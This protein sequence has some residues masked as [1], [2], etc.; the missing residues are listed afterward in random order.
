MCRLLCNCWN[1]SKGKL[2]IAAIPRY[3]QPKEQQIE[4]SVKK[5]TNNVGVQ[6]AKLISVG[7]FALYVGAAWSQA[8][9]YFPPLPRAAQVYSV[10]SLPN[11]E[12]YLAANLGRVR[13]ASDL[14]VRAIDKGFYDLAYK[15]LAY[16]DGRVEIARPSVFLGFSGIGSNSGFDANSERNCSVRRYDKDESVIWY[17]WVKGVSCEDVSIAD[18]GE[19]WLNSSIDVLTLRSDGT[20]KR[21]L[22][23]AGPVQTQISGVTPARG[24]NS[25]GAFIRHEALASSQSGVV[26]YLDAT[27]VERWRFQSDVTAPGV[28]ALS[29]GG[30]EVSGSI[31]RVLNAS[32]V[33]TSQRPNATIAGVFVSDATNA[34]TGERWVLTKGSECALT[35][36]S[37]TG[38]GEWRTILP[39]AVTM[40]RIRDPYSSDRGLPLVLNSQAS[41]A[42]VGKNVVALLSQNGA[43]IATQT[44]GDNGVSSAALNP[45]GTQL[46]YVAN[47]TNANVGDDQTLRHISVATQLDRALN[48]PNQQTGYSPLRA[49]ETAPDGTTF[50]VTYHSEDSRETLTAIAENGV[51]RWQKEL[52]YDGFYETLIGASNRMVCL[53]SSIRSSESAL[54]CW[55]S[56]TGQPLFELKKPYGYF[57]SDLL[58]GD[59][60][61]APSMRVYGDRVLIARDRLNPSDPFLDGLNVTNYEAISQTGVQLFA[62]N[63]PGGMTE[64]AWGTF[65]LIAINGP[66]PNY[67]LQTA[68]NYL[69]THGSYAGFN[70]AD[71]V[72][73]TWDTLGRAIGSRTYPY[74]NSELRGISV[75]SNGLIVG[76]REGTRVASSDPRQPLAALVPGTLFYEFL[77][78]AG[79][80][81][82]RQPATAFDTGF[83]EPGL[84]QDIYPTVLTTDRI[85]LKQDFRATPAALY[86]LRSF[87]AGDFAT[88]Q[89]R[90]VLQKI[91]L[92]T[93]ALI[94]RKTV[95][96]D[97]EVSIRRGPMQA[98]ELPTQMVDGK[99]QVLVYGRS[100]S[101][102]RFIESVDA[103]SGVSLDIQ[104]LAEVFP[105]AAAVTVGKM[106]FILRQP[107]PI[108]RGV[109]ALGAPS[110]LG[111]W[112]NPATPGQGFFIER[113][114]NTQFMAWFHNDW[115]SPDP[116]VSNFLS[117]ARQRWLSLQGELA[118][119]ATQ[120]ELKIY[121]TSGGSFARDSAG[122]PDEIGRATLRFSSCDSATLTYELRAQRCDSATCVAQ[123]QQV[124]ML[125]GVIPLRALVPASGCATPLS[126]PAP[127]SAKTGLF[128][129]P[130]VSGQG[131]I[132]VA[133]AGTL[134]AGWF[135]RDPLGAADDPQ[136]QA[137][138][139]LQANLGVSSSEPITAK[140]YRTLGGRRDS[141]LSVS[142][143]EVG[144]ATLVFA[145]CD[146][147][148][149]RYQFGASDAVKP[150][151]NLAGQLNLV[152]IGGCR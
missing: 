110:Q 28:R 122:T 69:A 99:W 147:L 8:L 84:I 118:P 132:T 43:L 142:S 83:L 66:Q 74:A 120:A 75:V 80:L 46:L 48:L 32:G 70:D 19:I 64:H 40:A 90:A 151:Q 26:A 22:T 21:K 11:G 63:V 92:E 136:K 39:C 73:S 51:V 97:P 13:L 108:A 57:P 114:G 98:L 78:Q 104:P 38:T 71:V 62:F 133:H 102:D 6:A 101:G 117:P 103:N 25:G 55:D 143:Q 86:V 18:S 7:V 76:R 4:S 119:G 77:D 148:S 81:T 130:N 126:L 53:T 150:F 95:D 30:V 128:H 61:S 124:G 144:E 131:L 79:R 87:E 94:W 59:L 41:L 24:P 100:V 85:E 58:L 56:A 123:G 23:T 140:I 50:A 2:K 137:W 16:G 134:F 96:V 33:A 44:V 35:K 107:P 121:Q 116:S 135:A 149:M 127:I 129:D 106:R 60:Q 12:F 17:Q 27:G 65:G 5:T 138:F 31:V 91:S 34:Q 1:V 37:A 125:H 14:S 3:D 146:Q 93:G 82:W 49:Q 115:D 29:D 10:S 105:D 9:I 89:Q 109:Q 112:Y 42:V 67:S 52:D 45:L 68:L 36:L 54:T 141:A 15:T 145:R 139:T 72:L 152:R 88:P 20:L 113:I 111:A 47:G